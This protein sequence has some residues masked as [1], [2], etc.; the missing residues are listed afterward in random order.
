M[1]TSSLKPVVRLEI[2]LEEIVY[3]RPTKVINIYDPS[4]HDSRGGG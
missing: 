1:Q 3:R 2:F 4:K